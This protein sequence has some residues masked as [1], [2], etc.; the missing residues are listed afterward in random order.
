MKKKIVAVLICGA[1]MASLAA[2]GSTDSASTDTDSAT[3]TAT[4]ET[5]AEAE[6][7]ESETTEAADGEVYNLRLGSF[8]GDNFTFMEEYAA[9]V[10]EASDGR[11]QIEVINFTTTGSTA[12]AVA[13]TKAGSYDMMIISG[14][15]YVGYEPCSAVVA[16][17]LVVDNI[18]NAYALETAM[19]E[20]GYF[21]DWDGEV[22]AVMLTDMQYI[23]LADDEITSAADFNGLIGRCQN[24]NGV[25]VLQELGCSITT[26]AT[27]DVYM[28]LETGVI[29][30]A[31]S[32]PT[33]MVSNAYDEVVKYI[34]DQPLY[35]DC[36]CLVMNSDSYASL[37]ADIQQILQDCADQL[38]ADYQAW[39]VAAETDCIQSM[40]DAGIEFISCPD[41]VYEIIEG[42]TDSCME[43]FLDTL[44]QAGVDTD[45]FKTFVDDTLAEIKGE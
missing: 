35:C 10:E 4:T 32:S 34:I 22:L 2:C 37:P 18:E 7:T 5:S 16:V 3:E 15:E 24:A 6:E 42:E 26:I 40:K 11:V 41:D 8:P 9:N 14:S 30:F 29:D 1:L 12:D 36:N 45:A 39:N 20:E 19:L 17:P 43:S 27:T 21:S 23:A 38:S 44:A 33:N 13:M 31:V 25:Q 28:S